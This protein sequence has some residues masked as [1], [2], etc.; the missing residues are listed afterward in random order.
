M[1][2]VTVNFECVDEEITPN[3]VGTVVIRVFETDDTFVTSFTSNAVTGIATGSLD[4]SASPNPHLYNIRIYK[5]GHTVDNPQQISIYDPPAGAPTGTND[6]KI[7]LD[8]HAAQAPADARLCRLSGYFRNIDGTPA[9]G[10]STTGPTIEQKQR[11]HIL[12]FTSL[13]DPL[14]VDQQG[15]FSSPVYAEAD[16]DGLIEVD[17]FREGKYSVAVEDIHPGCI[18]E[19]HKIIYVPDRSTANLLDILFPVVIQVD[20]SPAGPW[21]VSVGGSLDVTPTVTATDYRVISG[22]AQGDVEYTVD[23]T[24]IATVG[25]SDESTLSIQGVSSGSTQLRV[26]RRDSTI[27]R[28]PGDITGGVVDITVT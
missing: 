13:M 20:W 21:A 16:T 4:G 10:R 15:T 19:S 3:P 8:P 24:T 11:G 28:I 25:A 23:D 26:S 1:G 12:R 9:N 18:Q 2:L 14:I 22:I 17:L 27:V 7:T 6:F 5:Y